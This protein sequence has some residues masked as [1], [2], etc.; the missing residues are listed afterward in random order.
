[1]QC[2]YSSIYGNI[3]FRKE[4]LSDPINAALEIGRRT[5]EYYNQY[6]IKTKKQIHNII[7]P[8]ESDFKQSIAE[9]LEAFRFHHAN[10]EVKCA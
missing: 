7:K 9:A 10:D 5:Y 3:I 1:M 2:S 8:V 4:G 6:K